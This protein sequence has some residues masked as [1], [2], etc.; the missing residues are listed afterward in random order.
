M[1]LLTIFAVIFLSIVPAS[2]NAARPAI[3]EGGYQFAGFSDVKVKGFGP[4]ALAAYVNACT[5]KFGSGAR[6]ASSKEML[7]AMNIPTEPADAVAAWVRPIIV[8][9]T[10]HEGEI[11]FTEYSGFIAQ[12]LS[13]VYPVGFSYG[14]GLLYFIGEG[15]FFPGPCGQEFH[16]ACSTQ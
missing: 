9:T 6:W 7:E 8:D 5:A 4:P 11:F 13:C 10:S 3:T 12:D 16:V 14:D 2:V 15:Q 1:K